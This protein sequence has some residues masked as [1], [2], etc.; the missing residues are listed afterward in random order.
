M[1]EFFNDGAKIDEALLADV[2]DYLQSLTCVRATSVDAFRRTHATLGELGF[3]FYNFYSDCFR[4]HCAW[5]LRG[6]GD[7]VIVKS[8]ARGC[9]PNCCDLDGF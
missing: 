9:M 1:V 5:Q 8:H 2:E 4:C 7:I 6:L 3:F